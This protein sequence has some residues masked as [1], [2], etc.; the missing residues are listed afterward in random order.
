M[1]N[2][3]AMFYT[4]STTAV[5]AMNLGT[6]SSYT[7]LGPVES[8]LTANGNDVSMNLSTIVSV[9]TASTVSLNARSSA[10]GVIIYQNGRA[11]AIGAISGYTAV[12]IA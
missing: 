10:A 12:R 5:C 2:V 9:T 8:E 3:Q 4:T 1:L 7:V 11:F 6:S